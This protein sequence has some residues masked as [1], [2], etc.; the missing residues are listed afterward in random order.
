MYIKL[1]VNRCL[2]Y[3]QDQLKLLK[4]NIDKL[5]TKIHLAI[6]RIFG[7][8]GKIPKSPLIHPVN[9]SSIPPVTSIPSI[10]LPSSILSNGNDIKKDDVLNCLS[11]ASGSNV[12]LDQVKEAN[13]NPPSSSL[14]PTINNNSIQ[15]FQDNP[16][17]SFIFDTLGQK[18]PLNLKKYISKLGKDKT[19]ELLKDIKEN[20]RQFL[21]WLIKFSCSIEQESNEEI[22]KEKIIKKSEVLDKVF[23]RY[24]LLIKEMLLQFP[25]IFQNKLLLTN[26]PEAS[27]P[28]TYITAGGMHLL[29]EYYQEKGIFPNGVIACNNYH[30]YSEK[31]KSIADQPEGD[32][33]FTITCCE[34]G[35]IGIHQTGVLVVKKNGEISEFHFDS[36]AFN[37]P[38]LK[39]YGLKIAT[40]TY[41]NFSECELYSLMDL[42]QRDPYG[43]S[44][45]TM[46]D[47]KT[48]A[49]DKERI[50]QEIKAN[51]DNSQPYIFLQI[52]IALL[53]ELTKEFK[54][55]YS[56]SKE[57]LYLL[58]DLYKKSQISERK[59]S[60]EQFSS[61]LDELK[62]KSAGILTEK[63]NDLIKLQEEKINQAN[64]FIK[65]KPAFVKHLHL[66]KNM[67]LEFMK[68][69]QSLSEL[70]SVLQKPSKCALS[71]TL[72]KLQTHKQTYVAFKSGKEKYLYTELKGIKYRL[73][74]LNKTFHNEWDK[75]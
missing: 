41:P 7:F 60:E 32:W 54:E 48:V 31:L 74:I 61:L 68:S 26:D 39:N 34:K 18:S 14:G 65:N 13:A 30:E 38:I 47:L 55:K 69:V 6:L 29:G 9:R 28:F 56:S 22:K 17:L 43:C 51:S 53:D 19:I 40:L 11:I 62:N 15:V 24:I 73:E 50:L 46:D 70:K 33:Y 72:N 20:Y 49:L 23:N 36:G 42:R 12:A 2:N 37:Y 58:N 45:F 16:K 1:H 67:P 71:K 27:Y 35:E 52:F 44:F 5:T 3:A 21:K 4:S 57:Y 66:I 8:Q 10:S 64:S 25:A 59:I 63:E 75:L